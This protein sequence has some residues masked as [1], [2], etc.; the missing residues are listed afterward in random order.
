MRLKNPVKA[1]QVTDLPPAFPAEAIKKALGKAVVSQHIGG[2][3]RNRIG[4][5][6]FAGRKRIDAHQRLAVRFPLKQRVAIS[7]DI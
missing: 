2:G 5:H 6:V 3:G 1:W 4:V 7:D